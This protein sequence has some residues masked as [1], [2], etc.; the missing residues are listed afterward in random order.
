MTTS[1]RPR[2]LLAAAQVAV[3]VEETHRLAHVAEIDAPPLDDMLDALL[4]GLSLRA[5]MQAYAWAERLDAAYRQ[6]ERR[7]LRV[8]K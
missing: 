7:P 1:L 8:V 3:E 5:Q 6:P 2:D 4:P